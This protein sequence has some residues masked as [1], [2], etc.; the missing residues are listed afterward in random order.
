M[1][2][3]PKEEEEKNI[4]TSFIYIKK[5]LHLINKIFSLT[6]RTPYCTDFIYADVAIFRNARKH[7]NDFIFLMS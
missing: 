7:F 2:V 6:R 4:F 3:N 1:E 5:M